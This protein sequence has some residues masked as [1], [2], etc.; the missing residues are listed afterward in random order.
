MDEQLIIDATSAQRS[1]RTRYFLSRFPY[2]TVVEVIGSASLPGSVVTMQWQVDNTMQAMDR[3][4]LVQ[5]LREEW[6]STKHGVTQNSA[7]TLIEIGRENP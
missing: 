4:Y 1:A 6:E 3:D 5:Q 7:M 2:I